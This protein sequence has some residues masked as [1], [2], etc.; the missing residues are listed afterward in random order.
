MLEN[1]KSPYLGPMKNRR[2]YHEPIL[3]TT[4]TTTTKKTF[5]AAHDRPR[6]RQRPWRFSPGQPVH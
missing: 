5:T 4:T 2:A 6:V 3:K 1:K